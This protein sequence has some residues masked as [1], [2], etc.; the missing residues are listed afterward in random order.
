MK[1]KTSEE[2]NK[3]NKVNFHTA[4]AIRFIAVILVLHL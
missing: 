4:K 1:S 2:L 3:V